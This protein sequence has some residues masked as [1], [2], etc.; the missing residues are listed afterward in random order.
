MVRGYAPVY[1]AR[2][3]KANKKGTSLVRE[4]PF[5]NFDFKIY[6]DYPLNLK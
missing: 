3:V 5:V 6:S 1:V 4:S 2:I